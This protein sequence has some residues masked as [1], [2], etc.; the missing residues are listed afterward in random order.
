V[1][2]AIGARE[3]PSGPWPSLAPDAVLGLGPEAGTDAEDELPDAADLAGRA[4][5]L[6]ERA[7][8]LAVP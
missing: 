5:A 3:T 6:R 1:P 2:D 7:A 4:D 8:A